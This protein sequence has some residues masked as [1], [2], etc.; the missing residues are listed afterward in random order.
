MRRLVFSFSAFMMMCSSLSLALPLEVELQRPGG[1]AQAKLFAYSDYIEIK[2]L[3]L[4]LIGKV[5]VVDVRGR[6]ELFLIKPDQSKSL[7]GWAKEGKL[8]DRQGQYMGYYGWTA[9][10]VYAYNREGKKMGQAKCIASRGLCAA[11]TAAY[12][13]GLLQPID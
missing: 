1:Q 4:Q 8:Y 5:G 6:L 3:G 11:A 10:W 7:V 13:S 9:F 12:S 2:T